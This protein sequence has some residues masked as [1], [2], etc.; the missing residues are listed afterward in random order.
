M[1]PP[2]VLAVTLIY[3]TVANSH[4][5]RFVNVIGIL[6]GEVDN[7]SWNESQHEDS[8]VR[9]YTED[10]NHTVSPILLEKTP[11][12][13]EVAN[14]HDL[15]FVGVIEILKGEEYN[16]SWN[17]SQHEDSEVR[18]YTEDINPIV[19]PTALEKTQDNS[20][21]ANSRF[22]DDFEI[23]EGEKDNSSGNEKQHE[24]SKI[25]AH[26][27]DINHIVTPIL[28]EKTQNNSEELSYMIPLDKSKYVLHLV[29]NAKLT[30]PDFKVFSYNESQE[31]YSCPP[32][33]NTSCYYQGYIE[34]HPHSAVAINVCSGL[35][36]TMY[37]DDFM[38]IIEPD[39]PLMDF[40]HNVYNIEASEPKLKC[41]LHLSNSETEGTYTDNAKKTPE[42]G[43]A[44]LELF[45]VVSYLQYQ[46]HD[47]N[48]TSVIESLLE[49]I[50]HVNTVFKA[51]DTK[52]ILVGVEIWSKGNLIDIERDSAEEI[53]SDF[54][55]WTKKSLNHRITYDAIGL[56]LRENRMTLSGLARWRG[57]CDPHNSA[58]ISLM[59][60][61]KLLVSS[62]TFIHDLGH[63]LGMKHDAPGC[64]CQSEKLAC[65]MAG[66][67][68]LS[69]SFSNCSMMDM[70][71]FYTS[72]NASCL[73][74]RPV[75]D[76]SSVKATCGNNIVEAGEECDCGSGE[77]CQKNLCCNHLTCKLKENATC[78]SG[79]CCHKC[80]LLAKGKVCRPPSTECDL[81]EYC[82]GNASSCPT[83]VYQQDG[84]PC[85]DGRSVC[86]KKNCYDYNKHCQKLF[87]KDA[88]VAPLSC[89]QT[90]NTAGDRFGNC[91]KDGS[92][93]DMDIQDVMCGQI[94][95][96]IVNKGLPHHVLTSY[97]MT[98]V[99]D[100]LC[101]GLHFH[102][103]A[104]KHGAVPDGALCDKEKICL[105]KKCVD[106]SKLEYDC[107]AKR[108]CA[109]KGVCNNKK[110]CHC[111]K[112]WAPPYCN[113]SGYGG[114][115]D[116][117]P[118]TNNSFVKFIPPKQAKSGA[119]GAVTQWGRSLLT[120]TCLPI[121]ATAYM[122]V[123]T[124][125]P[126]L[127]Y[128]SSVANC[129]KCHI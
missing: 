18:P 56:S 105:D 23:L 125:A 9:P 2:L 92:S 54:L 97:I 100:V 27:E 37:T 44:H 67:G 95:C 109:G 83:D 12:N 111:N 4:D 80:K 101:W 104:Y 91:G 7:L 73:W 41:G 48:T 10:I 58:F 47:E 60:R 124:K 33:I 17:E 87:G 90:I 11:N 26:A 82:D 117:G 64:R 114:S 94:Q 15:R 122:I 68:L 72:A 115:I 39:G 96:I 5:L 49:L 123:S 53:L 102:K 81:A 8:Q 74:N 16:L 1:S 51:L 40:R 34:G 76:V 75:P 63:V 128:F 84:S 69:S 38:Y 29:H 46:F 78:S 127:F 19:T 28:L 36:G 30:T 59:D 57:A 31:L 32:H 89:F 66:E 88:S 22:V 71:A 113:R 85:N 13:S 121:L 120:L 70:E 118:L 42:R 14:S 65:A 20:E 79:P 112:E 107:D 61:D 25:R 45:M 6:E 119:S 93:L 103:G 35:R 21:V 106:F 108:T 116:S 77:V 99:G 55:K 43:T 110:N 86:Y 62:A 24:D 98:P 129:Y 126:L 50:N 52:I 3:L